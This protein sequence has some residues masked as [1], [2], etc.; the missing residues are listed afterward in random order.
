MRRMLKV[1][2]LLIFS[3]GTVFANPPASLDFPQLKF[4]PPKAIC[5]GNDGKLTSSYYN[6]YGDTRN[7]ALQY[8]YYRPALTTLSVSVVYV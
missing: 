8:R 2:A 1:C 3:A 4:N 7:G 6:A 5:D